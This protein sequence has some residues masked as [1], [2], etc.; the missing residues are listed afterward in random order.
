MRRQIDRFAR[1][2]VPSVAILS[3]SPMLMAVLDTIDRGISFP[4]REFRD[5][6][7]N[8]FR[9][10][11]GVGNRIL[12][13]QSYY[14]TSGYATWLFL[15]LQDFTS[16]SSRVVDIGCGCGRTARAVRD[17]ALFTGHYIGIDVDSEMIA[18]CNM[19]FPDKERFTFIHA[20][21]F[22]SVYN[23]AGKS[24]P[25]KLPLE[26]DSVDLVFSQAL[27]THLLE[28][29][30]TGYIVESNRILKKGRM[31]VMG[32]FCME[33]MQRASLLGGRW[34]FDHR[35]GNA[36]VES[37]Q[38]PEAAVGYSRD[39]LLRACDDAGFSFSEIRPGAHSL[40]VCRK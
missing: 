16:L 7:P 34:K 15:L 19:H 5:L 33:D 20:D 30:V 2:V 8:R 39:Y 13:N 38:Y 29:D 1:T 24:S 26:N 3:K 23:P 21:V 36:F 18:W 14:I 31:M 40:L 25:Y 4:F 35:V 6:P 10:R 12:F 9:I 28:G 27:F 11:V 22:S 32:I 17:S 37:L